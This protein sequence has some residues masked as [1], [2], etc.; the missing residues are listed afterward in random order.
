M[1]LMR[2]GAGLGRV[3]CVPER[4]DRNQVFVQQTGKAEKGCVLRFTKGPHDRVRAEERSRMVPLAWIAATCG[5]AE[6]M[7]RCVRGQAVFGLWLF[8]FEGTDE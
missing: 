7:C 2:I 1:V 5:L 8:V 3:G 4:S 6:R